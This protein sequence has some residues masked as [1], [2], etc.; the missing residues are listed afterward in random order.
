MYPALLD[1]G[2]RL[3]EKQRL[4]PT[5]FDDR[6]LWLSDHADCTSRG[7]ELFE[8]P[9]P[10]GCRNC[11]EDLGPHRQTLFVTVYATHAEAET[12]FSEL[13]GPCGDIVASEWAL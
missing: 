8:K 13:C 11:N 1:R 10:S 2:T 5:H 12:W 4:C 3:G 6:L 9:E 7:D